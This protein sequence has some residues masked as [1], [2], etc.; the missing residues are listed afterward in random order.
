[1][2]QITKY[3]ALVAVLPLLTVA[4]VGGT[5]DE[6]SAISS[7][8]QAKFAEYLKTESALEVKNDPS[9]ELVDVKALPHQSDKEHR[10]IF[11]VFAGDNT[12][13]DVQILVKSDLETIHQ[14]AIGVDKSGDDRTGMIF[15][16]EYAIV[17]VDIKVSDPNTISVEL[18]GYQTFD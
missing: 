7:G 11:K 18:L 1:M 10:A 13:R 9:V 3:A 16:G 14:Q 4:I 17:T 5:I 2:K 15:A 8:S 12:I 6:A